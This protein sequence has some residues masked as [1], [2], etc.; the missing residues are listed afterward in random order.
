MAQEH[1]ATHADRGTSEP[2]VA[3]VRT[4]PVAYDLAAAFDAQ[5]DALAI[6]HGDA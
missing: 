2:A 6:D 3:W 1:E 4:D 5:A